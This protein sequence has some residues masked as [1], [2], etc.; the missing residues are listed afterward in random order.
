MAGKLEDAENQWE[1]RAEKIKSGE[2]RN[3]WDM[4]EERGFVKDVAG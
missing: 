3:I 2:V 1:A 4:L